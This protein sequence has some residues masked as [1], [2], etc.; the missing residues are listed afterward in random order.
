MLQSGDQQVAGKVH[1]L[2]RGHL[3]PQKLN[4]GLIDLVGLIKNNDTNGR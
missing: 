2:P 3:R 4:A 1:P